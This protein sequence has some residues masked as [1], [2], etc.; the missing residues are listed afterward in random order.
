MHAFDP[1]LPPPKKQRAIKIW[2]IAAAI[3]IVPS[4]IA[5]IVRGLAFAL[6]CAPGLGACR[7]LP[8]GI[9]LHQALNLCWFIA[10]DSLIAVAVGFVAAVAALLARRPLLG[11]LSMLVLP[12]ASL[13]L[14]TMAVYF[15]TY[16]DCAVSET[17]IGDCVLWGDHMGMAFHRAAMAPGLIDSFVSYVFAL[18][19]MIA[20][21][22]FAFFRPKRN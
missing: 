13:A 18:A 16:P 9:V 8:L 2:A 6:H 17:G 21:L 5:W 7:N 12:I 1:P 19:V 10:S 15:T 14:P 20:I 3:L 11:A 4:L 22:G